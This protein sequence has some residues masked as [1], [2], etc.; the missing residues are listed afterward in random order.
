[1]HV[2]AF[3]PPSCVETLQVRASLGSDRPRDPHIR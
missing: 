1:V 2:V 3:K